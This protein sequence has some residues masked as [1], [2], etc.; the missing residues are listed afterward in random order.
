[1]ANVKSYSNLTAPTFTGNLEG[2]ASTAT[3]LA[4]K[5]KINI[6]GVTATAQDFDGTTNITI[7]ITAV[8]GALIT[9][10]IPSSTKA[11]QDSD[12][13]AINTTYLKKSGGDMSGT[14]NF[15]NG[16]GQGLYWKENTFGDKFKICPEFSGEDDSNKFRIQGAVGATGTDPTLYDLLTITGKSG[17]AWIKGS[18]TTGGKLTTNGDAIINGTS[19]YPFQVFGNTSEES[20]LVVNTNGNLTTKGTINGYTLAAAC[21]RGV[22][23]LSS[24]SHS[25]FGTNNNYVPDISFIS[26]WNGAYESNGASNLDKCIRGNIVGNSDGS[27]KNLRV[28]STSTYNSSVSSLPNG[29]I[30]A[31]Y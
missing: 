8:P 14:I 18:L 17:N 11:T 26:Y 9:G 21:A 29:T 7:P 1:M 23:T 10:S 6:S 20:L 30:V 4:T 25:G 15:L 31:V 19:T 5:I 24:G 3:K 16:N 27:A 28:M 2:N 12:G 13:N 22:K